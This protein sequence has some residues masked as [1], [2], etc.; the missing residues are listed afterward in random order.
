MHERENI[1]VNYFL[2]KDFN[3]FIYSLSDK[4]RSNR[5]YFLGKR[6]CGRKGLDKVSS[7]IL[8]C[9]RKPLRSIAFRT[10]FRSFLVILNNALINL[11]KKHPKEKM[12]CKQNYIKNMPLDISITQ[13]N[14]LLKSHLNQYYLRFSPELR[15]QQEK[16]D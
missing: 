3:L 16:S 11:L 6:T 13:D 15:Y 1:L 4:A 9:K 14:V 7:N 10:S 12:V 8:F 2:D 5:D